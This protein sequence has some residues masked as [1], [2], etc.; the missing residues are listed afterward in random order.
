MN[1]KIENFIIK[2]LVCLPIW[3]FLELLSMLDPIGILPIEA[4][5][6]LLKKRLKKLV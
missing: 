4:L 2:Y 1:K 5:I 3:L 6:L